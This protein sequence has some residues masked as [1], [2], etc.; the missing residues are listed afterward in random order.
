MISQH[1]TAS[2]AAQAEIVS[3]I[4]SESLTK[5]HLGICLLCFGAKFLETTAGFADAAGGQ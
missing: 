3:A 5:D 4:P 1:D 2:A